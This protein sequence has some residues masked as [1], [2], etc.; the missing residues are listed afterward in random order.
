VIDSSGETDSNSLSLQRLDGFS[1][2]ISSPDDVIVAGDKITFSYEI[3]AM[4]PIYPIEYPIQW[5]VMVSGIADSATTGIVNS[6]SGSIE[7]TL[8]NNLESGSYLFTFIFEGESTHFFLD[9]R[10]NDDASGVGGTFSA[11]GDS[12]DSASGWVST[13]ALIMAFACLGLLLKGRGKKEEEWSGSGFNDPLPVASPIQPVAA[14]P[15]PMP[16]PIPADNWTPAAI[17]AAQPPPAAMPAY[18]PTSPT[19]YA[20]PP[21]LQ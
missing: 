9:V 4:D 14:V 8:P 13:L 11:V 2:M 20:Q 7:Y 10:S 6:D 3:T 18:D 16:A 5:S 1:L 21:P 15:A 12:L 19:G 17:P